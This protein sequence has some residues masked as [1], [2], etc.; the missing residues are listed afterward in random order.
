LEAISIKEHSLILEDLSQVRLFT[1][2]A[3]KV[4]QPSK[5]HSISDFKY[6][7]EVKT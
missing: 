1:G 2:S 4:R 6:E 3:I 5:K 7:L